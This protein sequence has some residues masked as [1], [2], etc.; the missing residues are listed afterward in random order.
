[1]SV[2]YQSG[3]EN[4]SVCLDEVMK[5]RTKPF[6]SRLRFPCSGSSGVK[7]F[8]RLGGWKPEVFG[9]VFL[10]LFKTFYFMAKLCLQL[11]SRGKQGKTSGLSP[12]KSSTPI[13]TIY[14]N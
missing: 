6:V 3:E 5:L 12:P 9:M 14:K 13:K 11:Q 4:D 8:R 1:M 7:V 2:T 10:G